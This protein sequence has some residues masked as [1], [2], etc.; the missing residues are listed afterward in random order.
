VAYILL[1]NSLSSFGFG[2]ANAHA[3]LETYVPDKHP[4]KDPKGTNAVS[5][6]PFVFSAA[7]E[8]SLSSYMASFCEYLQANEAE[9]SLRD[10][11]L[12][13]HS[14]RTRFPFATTIAALT[15]QDLRDKIEHKLQTARTDTDQ[16]VGI[17]PSFKSSGGQKSQI[18]GVFTG[19]GAQSARMGAAL[20][21]SSD[22]ARRIIEK[23][24]VRLSRLPKSD[25]PSWSL[26]AEL[27]KDASS[28]RISQ[29]SLSQPLCTAVQILQ[30]KLLRAAS[31]EFSAVVGHS[32]GEIGAAYA[33]GLISAEDAICIAYYRGL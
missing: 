6:A 33:A 27:L 31:I 9:S 7:S 10:L 16:P 12:T 1:T 32:S 4:H 2:G 11:A 29:A 14:R 28:S 18:L 25:R 5:F 23:L 19:Q 17:R 24:E 30:V 20:I 8:K 3:I 15:V 21:E 26:K 13:L 22:A